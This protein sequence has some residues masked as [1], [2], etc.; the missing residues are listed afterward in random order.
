MADAV[1]AHPGERGDL[2]QDPALFEIYNSHRDVF[3][4]T[5][6]RIV[7]KALDS[8]IS[9]DGMIAEIGSGAGHLYSLL[10]ESYRTRVVGIEGTQRFA[11]MQKK[12]FPESN[13]AVGDA[14]SLPIADDS[15]RAVL[16]YSVYD[17]FQD[18][19]KAVAET[20][21]V[22]QK[23]GKFIH[24]LDLQPNFGILIKDIPHD[25]IPF[26]IYKSGAFDRFVLV[27]REDYTNKIRPRLNPL[28]VMMFDLYAKDPVN[29]L[30]IIQLKGDHYIGKDMADTIGNISDVKKTETPS[31]KEKFKDKLVDELRQKGFR[32][33]KDADMTETMNVAPNAAHKKN[34]GKNLFEGDVGLLWTKFDPT[35]PAGMIREKGTL[36]IVVAEKYSLNFPHTLTHYLFLRTNVKIQT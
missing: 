17:T 36:Q 12:S 27:S 10:P 23:G 21:R 26:P 29:T 9:T 32:I 18:L 35:V 15:V 33:I 22:L 5:H 4:E 25:Q 24:F 11:G 13:V 16:S 7:Q 34:L 1:D 14:Y 6:A 3:R 30:G 8:Y 2:W 20:G 31:M 28:K 19:Q